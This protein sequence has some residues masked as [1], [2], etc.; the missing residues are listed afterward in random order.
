MRIKPYSIAVRGGIIELEIR[1]RSVE[2]S[3]Q[4]DIKHFHT[5]AALDAFKRANR[6]KP[7]KE[8]H[9]SR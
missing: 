5:A 4:R 1:S 7:V 9:E 8:Q 2:V 3:T 6:L